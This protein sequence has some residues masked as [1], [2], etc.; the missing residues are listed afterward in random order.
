MGTV[1]RAFNANSSISGTITDVTMGNVDGSAFQTRYGDISGIITN[2]TM[3]DVDPSNVYGSTDVGGAFST[4][5]NNP[6][7][8]GDISGIITNIIMGN[9]N[10]AFFAASGTMSAIIT[11]IIIGNINQEAF[12]AIFGISGIITD[13]I[14][15]DVPKAFL[16][17]GDLSNGIS[18]TLAGTIS[19]I[20]MGDCGNSFGSI[21]DITSTISYVK[22][23][24]N[25]FQTGNFSGKLLD[26]EFDLRTKNRPVIGTVSS[27][28]IIERCKL[29]TDTGVTTI[30]AAS[31]GTN[32]QIL[33]TVI[34]NGTSNITVVPS[35]NNY[36]IPTW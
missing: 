17:D 6:N 36:N 24:G 12:R 21:G 19:N 2:I 33:Y 5:K 35:T 34:N 4:G 1:S 22:S 18:G 31:P 8:G 30:R 15:G 7:S 29:L 10:R 32:V 25:F 3:G 9:V 20:I 28:A 13:V 14:M 16:V 27:A 26:C 23:N 11:N